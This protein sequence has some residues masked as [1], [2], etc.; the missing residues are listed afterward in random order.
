MSYLPPIRVWHLAVTV[1]LAVVLAGV[2]SGCDDNA[3]TTEQTRT[4]V[5]SQ[6]THS[7]P[8]HLANPPEDPRAALHDALSS[9][10]VKTNTDDRAVLLD[11][12]RTCGVP[13]A[14][15][16]LV[17]SKTSHQ[18]RLISPSHPRAIYF[19]DD[20]YIGWVPGGLI[21]FC[22]SDPEQGTAFFLLDPFAQGPLCLQADASCLTCHGGARTNYK[23]GLMVRSVY[24]DDKGFAILSAGSFVTGHASPLHERWGGWYVTGTHGEMRHM[25]NTIAA[26]LGDRAS[27][28]MQAGA[29][30]Q[31]LDEFFDVRRYPRPGSDIVALMVLEHQVQMH[32]LLTQSSLM[33][34]EQSQRSRS[35]AESDGRAFDPQEADTL[36]SL[37]RHRAEEIVEHLLFTDEFALES[38]ICGD[39]AFVQAFAANRRASKQ[40]LSLKDFDLR[41]R[42]FR[43]RCSYM[44]YSRAF[45][46]MPQVLKA[47]VYRQLHEALANEHPP[48]AA[49]HLARQERED[50]AA[51]LRDTVDDLPAY[52][53]E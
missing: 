29:N 8:S 45:K 47:E 53:L 51:I 26:D 48:S 7:Q 52:W 46:Q 50:I 19:S 15:Q 4:A 34:R 41:T 6:P 20:C 13:E 18:D 5:Q 44:L 17:F 38:P 10:A 12:L 2:S 33:V 35:I 28:D 27:L 32:N 40:D 43:F 22:D 11:I 16:V 21:E 49:A 1:V 42:L 30:L 39:P 31:S 3:K 24:P 37:V 25:G 9:G 36:M 23:P 14:S